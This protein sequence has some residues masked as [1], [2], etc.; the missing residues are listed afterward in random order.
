[1]TDFSKLPVGTP[2][3]DY[4]LGPGVIDGRREGDVY[5]VCATFKNN[6]YGTYAHNGKRNLSD[7]RPSLFLP[8]QLPQIV[9]VKPKVKKWAIAFLFRGKIGDTTGWTKSHFSDEKDFAMWVCC[10]DH[11]EFIGLIKSTEK[12][13]PE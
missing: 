10:R 1:M 8:G 2:V 11:Y 9:E 5:P 13:F 12:E 7:A 3:E 4:L 6:A